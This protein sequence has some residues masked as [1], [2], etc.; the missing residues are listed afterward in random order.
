MASES[1]PEQTLEDKIRDEYQH[2]GGIWFMAH[3][4]NV[5]I[6]YIYKVLGMEDM[7]QVRTI[8]DL[9]D[10]GPLAANRNPYGEVYEVPY[11]KN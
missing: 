11:T 5:E 9:V 1:K 7:I 8:G 2:G 6:P 10:R 4:Y 3:K